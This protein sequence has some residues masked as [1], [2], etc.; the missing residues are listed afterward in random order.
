MNGITRDQFSRIVD[1]YGLQEEDVLE[2]EEVHDVLLDM[3]TQRIGNKEGMI[4]LRNAI[5]SKFKIVL[6]KKH[7]KRGMYTIEMDHGDFNLWYTPYDGGDKDLILTSM[8]LNKVDRY[9]DGILS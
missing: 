9:W 8:S 5:Q 1:E 2:I 6:R 3:K 4:L 7:T